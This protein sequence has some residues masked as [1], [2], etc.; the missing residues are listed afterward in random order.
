MAAV[1]RT[2]GGGFDHD[3][4]YSVANLQGFEL[5]AGASL[6]AKDGV[7]GFVET[8]VREFQPLTYISTGT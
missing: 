2:N 3:V 7:G 6:A 1:T 4:Q 8:V 5:D